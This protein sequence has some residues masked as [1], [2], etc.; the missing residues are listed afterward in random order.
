LVTDNTF[1]Q[2]LLVIGNTF[3]KKLL[4][5]ANTLS[6]NTPKTLDFSPKKVWN[7]Q[8]YNKFIHKV[9][10]FFNP[11]KVWTALSIA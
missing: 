4:V 7:S 10:H 9:L 2:K 8:N 11:K 6:P 5:K 3:G 1:Y